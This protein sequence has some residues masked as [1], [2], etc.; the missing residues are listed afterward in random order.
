MPRYKFTYHGI[1]P[2][3]QQR[4]TTERRINATRLATASTDC[5]LILALQF[6]HSLGVALPQDYC[7]RSVEVR[8]VKRCQSFRDNATSIRNYFR[9]S[10]DFLVD[11]FIKR[12]GFRVVKHLARNEP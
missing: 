3:L 7:A 4:L 9:Q 8:I 11:R 2:L 5:P 12:L 10:G 1:K 6:H